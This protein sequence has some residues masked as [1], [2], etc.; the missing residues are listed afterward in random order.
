MKSYSS[1]SSSS[2]S[3]SGRAEFVNEDEDKYE[4]DCA[5]GVLPSHTHTVFDSP[6]AP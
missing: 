4:D 2:F 5:F 6:F 1:S 3:A